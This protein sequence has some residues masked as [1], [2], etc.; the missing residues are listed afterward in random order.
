VQIST[1]LDQATAATKL[2][3][4]EESLEMLEQASPADERLVE[5][6]RFEIEAIET[7]PPARPEPPERST[8]ARL[9]AWSRP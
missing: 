5:L 9:G 8:S 2:H 1:G 3:R 6:L 4:Y 7:L